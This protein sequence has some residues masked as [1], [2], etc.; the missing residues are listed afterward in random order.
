MLPP[1]T[2]ELG[3]L[4]IPDF[5]SITKSPQEFSSSG[6]RTGCEVGVIVDVG[7]GVVAGDVVGVRV[8]VGLAVGLAVGT[9]VCVIRAAEDAVGATV[10]GLMELT[11]VTVL[12]CRVTPVS[13]S[14]LP[15]MDAPV[16]MAMLVWLRIVPSK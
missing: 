14:S 12:V 16:F 5:V 2:T 9:A 8:V 7:A 1:V 3:T 10:V 15:L 11:I 13:A 4:V 6:I